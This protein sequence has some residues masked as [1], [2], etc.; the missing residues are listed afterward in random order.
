[1]ENFNEV[2]NDFENFNTLDYAQKLALIDKYQ[3]ECLI[4]NINFYEKRIDKHCLIS[5]S[6]Y[7]DILGS[8]NA[9]N[10][11]LYNFS[12]KNGKEYLQLLSWLIKRDDLYFKPFETIKNK[13]LE[14]YQEANNK[15]QVLSDWHR[16]Y[17]LKIKGD[18]LLLDNH[19]DNQVYR[20]FYDFGVKDFNYGNNALEGLTELLFRIGDGI[21]YA[22]KGT[23]NISK[24]VKY[25]CFYFQG[26]ADANLLYYLQ[27]E[28][29]NLGKVIAPA[30][31]QK[32]F[33][34]GLTEPQLKALHQQLIDNTFLA[35][36]TKQEHFINAFNG[37]VLNGSFELLEWIEP[38]KGAI[39]I[40]VFTNRKNPWTKLQSVMVKANYSKLL[41]ASKGRDNDIFKETYNLLN[42]LKY[43]L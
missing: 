1:M 2:Q 36:N 3:I 40:E 13:F 11:N 10:L 25:C 19:F 30:T 33:D 22:D 4:T 24:I 5:N 37:K 43:S 41:S 29:E 39:F 9:H 38:T 7:N 32:G 21:I 42:H 6:Q 23:L 17:D 18:V 28:K 14:E 15:D 34:L 12:P 16:D 26:I 8:E 27:N 31:K 20:A 35:E